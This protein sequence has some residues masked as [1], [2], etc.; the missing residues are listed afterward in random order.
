MIWGSGQLTL[1]FYFSKNAQ[2][3]AKDVRNI[4]LARPSGLSPK[5][6]RRRLE[7]WHEPMSTWPRLDIGTF[8]AARM[9]LVATPDGKMRLAADGGDVAMPH[10]TVAQRLELAF[11]RAGRCLN[12]KELAEQVRQAEA[13]EGNHTPRFKPIKAHAAREVLSRDPRFQWVGRGT[14]GLTEWDLGLSLPSPASGRRSSVG[15]EIEYLLDQRGSIPMPELM[16]HLNRRFR[17][18]ER[19]IR[20]IIGRNPAVEIR[21]GVLHRIDPNEPG[22]VEA[23]MELPTAEEL[24]FCRRQ[25]DVLRELAVR[26][27]GMADIGVAAKLV[28]DSGMTTNT[29]RGIASNLHSHVSSSGEWARLGRNRVWLLEFGPPPWQLP[30]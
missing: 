4:L 18:L 10:R 12:Y 8:A 29:R 20:Q 3:L 1:S 7:E 23:P 17:V 15:M 30:A 11:H 21:Q 13:A 2:S 27:G 22:Q 19:T 6:M 16:E 24:K 9:D 26:N 5:D 28:V 25:V 14:Y